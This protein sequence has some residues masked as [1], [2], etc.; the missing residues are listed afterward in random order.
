[1]DQV[2]AFRDSKLSH[3]KPP[4]PVVVDLC[5]ADPREE[6]GK[7]EPPE[8]RKREKAE[9]ECTSKI[10]DSKGGQSCED[11]DEFPIEELPNSVL[12]DFFVDPKLCSPGES[13]AIR[14][15]FLDGTYENV[16][17]LSSTPTKFLLKYFEEKIPKQKNKP[18]STIAIFR[19][20][21][22]FALTHSN[23]GNLPVG[24][25]ELDKT[26]VACYLI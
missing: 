1:M 9:D 17:V 2:R 20:F 12:D 10:K 26:V 19:F 24:Q 7:E 8:T 11:V 4:E 16:C 15:R 21:D 13:C 23:H 25:M 3:T 22:R 6:I 5:D 18:I 14:L